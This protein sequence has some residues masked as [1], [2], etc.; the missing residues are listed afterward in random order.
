MEI[1]HAFIG[2]Q[3]Q[4]EMI[5]NRFHFGRFDPREQTK[6]FQENFFEFQR[7]EKNVELLNEFLVVKIDENQP[8]ILLE[9]LWEKLSQL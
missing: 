9:T 6:V 5:E 4:Y 2:L 8:K 7:R 1:P 3:N